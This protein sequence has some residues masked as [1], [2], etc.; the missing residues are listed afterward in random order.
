[1]HD[2][3]ELELKRAICCAG[4]SDPILQQPRSHSSPGSRCQ[5]NIGS[6]LGAAIA[7]ALMLLGPGAFSL[8][9]RRYG[10]REN[11]YSTTV[12]PFD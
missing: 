2:I 7:I 8:D 12:K 10:P 6:A 9:A 1:M 5:K 11:R 4:N 3:F